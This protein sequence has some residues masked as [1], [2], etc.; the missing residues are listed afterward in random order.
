MTVDLSGLLHSMWVA[1]LEQF[2]E[3][4]DKYLIPPPVF[5]VF[6]GEFLAFDP[7]NKTLSARF[8]ILK[9]YLNPYGALQGGVIAALIDNT[10]GPLSILVAPPNVTRRMEV[11]YS[12]PIKPDLENITIKSRLVER[13]DPKLIFKT[14]VYDQLGRTFSSA[15]SIHWIIQNE[16]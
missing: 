15:K 10:V 1:I 5:K 3:E 13:E 4:I 16:V 6:K 2:G 11:K 8:P 9:D 12:K 14:R 7:E